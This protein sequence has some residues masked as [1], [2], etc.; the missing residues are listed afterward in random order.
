MGIKTYNPT[1]PGVRGKTSLTFDEITR[2]HPE[3]SLVTRVPKRGGR[4]NNG[5]ITSRHKGGGHKRLFRIIDF[6]RNKLGILA[7]VASIEYDPNRSA[8]IAL[9][10]YKDGEK[11]YI[12]CPEGLKV[13]QEVSSG[14][15]AEIQVGN[16]LPIA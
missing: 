7:R 16:A 15:D 13:G 6:R 9:L 1:S 11:R 10:H 2:S 4:N 3:K 12:L 5:R 14:P 8:R